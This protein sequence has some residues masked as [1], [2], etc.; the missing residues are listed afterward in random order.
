[1]LTEKQKIN[2]QSLEKCNPRQRRSVR[3]RVTDKTKQSVEDITFVLKHADK[4]PNLKDKI[5]VENIQQLV[6]AYFEAYKIAPSY[7]NPKKVIDLLDENAKLKRT[8]AALMQEMGDMV[9]RIEH[10]KY[11]ATHATSLLE[12]SKH[13]QQEE[14]VMP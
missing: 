14:Y 8:N 11:L 4:F 13:L 3:K 12:K 2:I 9:H 10:F 5:S 7:S 6:D 1:M